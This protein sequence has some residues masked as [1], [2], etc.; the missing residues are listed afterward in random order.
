[1]RKRACQRRVIDGPAWGP[2]DLVEELRLGMGE[3]VL[4]MNSFYF[5]DQPRSAE[6]QIHSRG[7]SVIEFCAQVRA[8]APTDTLL[9]DDVQDPREEMLTSLGYEFAEDAD[10]PGL[11]VWTAPSDGCEISFQTQGQALR[12]AWLDACEQARAISGQDEAAWRALSVPEQIAAIEGALSEEPARE[13]G[14]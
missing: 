1:V 13:R 2:A 11:W 5:C 14:G 10:Q 12:S 6:G 9:L 3:L 8:M 7:I 4:S